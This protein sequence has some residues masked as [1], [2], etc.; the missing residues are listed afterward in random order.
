MKYL[1][2]WAG[3]SSLVGIAALMAS[4]CGAGSD[5]D[6][7]A[8]GASG[9]VAGGA[10]GSG[11]GAGVSGGSVAGADSGAGAGKGGAGASAGSA[12][13]GAKS[14]CETLRGRERSCGILGEGKTPC[15]DFYDAAE[16]CEIS[17]MERATCADII[18]YYCGTGYVALGTCYASCVGLAPVDCGDGNKLPGWARCSGT[19]DCA[20]GS[21]EAGCN[22]ANTGY[23][24]RNADQ[25]VA[26]EKLCD[27]TRDCSDA[28][29]ENAECAKR[30]CKVNGVDTQLASYTT[31]DGT[32]DCDDAS[33]EPTEC[34]VLACPK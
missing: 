27:G 5:G 10:G 24:C 6:S 11:A 21:D 22:A 14:Y 13:A 34:A 18:G 7:G 15:A 33:D 25:F 29:D 32:A 19:E 9:T 8:A 31:C 23:K 2:R 16:P 28:S 30:T 1:V 26:S 4:A 20:D 17:C 12:A 3:V